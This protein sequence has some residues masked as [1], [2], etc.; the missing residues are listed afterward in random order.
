M[1]TTPDGRDICLQAAPTY[2]APSWPDPASSMQM[3]LD[4]DVDDLDSSLTPTAALA[5]AVR[6]GS[7]TAGQVVA[8]RQIG[9]QAIEFLVFVL[10]PGFQPSLPLGSDD[11][12]D[13][14]NIFECAGSSVRPQG[15]PLA[16]DD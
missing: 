1:M 7:G 4:F 16:R 12:R 11:G 10:V 9:R 3:H 13:Y 8:R 15:T 14:P 5:D 6:V 2:E